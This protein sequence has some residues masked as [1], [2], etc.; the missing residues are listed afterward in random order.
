M[1][2]CNQ[3]KGAGNAPP[4][5]EAHPKNEKSGNSRELTPD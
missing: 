5:K 3:I 2:I 4:E 1:L